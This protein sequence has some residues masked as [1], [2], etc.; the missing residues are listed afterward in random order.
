[1]KTIRGKFD[2]KGVA[3]ASVAGGNQ[4]VAA[5]GWDR[6]MYPALLAAVGWC[7]FYEAQGATNGRGAA[8]LSRAEREHYAATD[9]AVRS[10]L[11]ALK[12]G[13]GV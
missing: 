8:A 4:A 1:L 10:A 6:E 3:E 2:A 13:G 12:G 9:V 5:A 7:G 11:K